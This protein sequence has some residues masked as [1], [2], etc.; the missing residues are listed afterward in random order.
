MN[1]TESLNQALESL[2]SNKLRSFLTMLGIIMGV[3]SVITIV[4]IGN[5]AQA[6][7]DTQF[8]QLGAN[9]I[10]ISYRNN[11]NIDQQDYLTLKDLDIIKK[12]VPEIKNI[13]GSRQSFGEVKV[14]KKSRTAI[15]YGVSSQIK[16]FMPIEMDKGRMINEMDIKNAAK[17]AVVDKNFAVKY[18]IGQEP[19]GKI[20]QLR[21]RG[22]Y[23]KLKIAGVTESEGNIFSNMMGE[24]FPTMIYIPVTTAMEIT[25]NK[26]LNEI[27]VSVPGNSAQLKVIGSRIIKA[28]EFTHKNK[29]KYRPS[30]SADIQKSLSGVL[31]VVSSV[32][33]V[34]AV[35]TLIVGGIGIV[36]ILL[37]SV[38]ERIREIGIRKALGARKGDIILQF[39][40]ESILMT[41]FSG[42]IGIFLG[43]LSGGI[44]SNLI[45]IPPVVDLKVIILSF[46]GSVLLGL[47]FGVYP[48][49]RAADLDPIESLRYE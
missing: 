40:T 22:G 21:I 23:V 41:G 5:A 25:G 37:V 31:G 6:Y 39:L 35:I 44:I 17:V 15:F 29:D 3:F 2:K 32:L 33:L 1:F 26:Q 48:A 43:I 27:R 46:L 9:T 4:A 36:N 45:K 16:S 47:V 20:I 14:G 19:I 11:N 18:L 12:A 7:M 28:L 13:L 49:K 10:Q 38:T 42:L 30:N 24:D 8:E 34:I